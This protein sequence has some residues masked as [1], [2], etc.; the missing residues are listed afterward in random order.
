VA[1]YT[2]LTLS[3][4]IRLL[5]TYGILPDEL[6]AIPG[7]AANSSFV[8][9]SAHGAFV[10][11]V[12]DNHTIESARLLASLM[13]YLTRQ[14]LPVDTVVMTTG[15]QAVSTAPHG[16]P[17]MLKRFI[18]GT[19]L[20]SANKS[21]LRDIG[22]S[23]ASLHNIPAPPGLPQGGRL[24]PTDWMEV[25]ADHDCEDLVDLVRD[26]QAI[27]KTPLWRQLPTGMCHGD[28]FGDNMIREARTGRIVILDWETASVDPLLL[29][30]G[31]TIGAFIRTNPERQISTADA[32]LRGYSSQRTLSSTE[33]EMLPSA[34]LY[35]LAMLAYQRFRRH[36]ILFPNPMLFDHYRELTS[37]AATLSFD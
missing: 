13:E 7:G 33:R 1:E 8:V 11:T 25:L 32:L 2:D 26:A 23:L 12:L 3:Q 21:D 16:I 14:G 9:R 22:A 37:L 34:I 28:F 5:A 30:L 20:V 27:A 29:D 19:T 36:N 17:I 6:S 15:G 4:G 24:I 18:P 10:L 35:G 31:I